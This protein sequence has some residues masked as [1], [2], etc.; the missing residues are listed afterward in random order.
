MKTRLDYFKRI[1]KGEIIKPQTAWE[2]GFCVGWSFKNA[3]KKCADKNVLI[4]RLKYLSTL[5]VSGNTYPYNKR[6]SK[7]F[8]CNKLCWVCKQ[9]R[10]SYYH[11]IILLANGGYNWG[12]N[13]IPICPDCHKQIHSWL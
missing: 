11:H 7:K 13:R 8:G 3:Y 12:F 1:K 2:E 9:S 10:A 5:K 4:N 6:R